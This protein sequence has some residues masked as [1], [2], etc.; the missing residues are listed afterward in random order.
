MPDY[1]AE[2][3]SILAFIGGVLIGALL[4][5]IIYGRSTRNQIK[6]IKQS[7]LTKK[8]DF[9]ETE[10]N[11][12]KTEILTARNSFEDLSYKYA[13]NT[14]ELKS[15]N[16]KLEELESNTES[17]LKIENKN[18]KA[19]LL[20]LQEENESALTQKN[21]LTEYQ[22][23]L[24][25]LD[26]AIKKA[27]KE[28]KEDA[29]ES[30]DENPFDEK[31]SKKAEANFE[32]FKKKF[33]DPESRTT[34]LSDLA[35]E[36]NEKPRKSLTEIYGITTEIEELLNANNILSF[37]DLSK[38]KISRLKEILAHQS[39]KFKKINPL[40]WPIQARLAIQG[41]W[42]ILDEYRDRMI[43]KSN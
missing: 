41:Q 3:L 38:T 17:S 12:I 20:E 28:V 21:Y 18:L 9:L 8:I 6:S 32:F 24:K 7:R 27:K 37:E 25:S 26:K 16:E 1:I 22:S 31:K 43:S 23:F 42:D 29:E 5:F 11:L 10:Q 34:K 19:K 40:N 14:K 35:S 36:I 33:M 4:H 30:E 13:S 2:N 15:I 39:P